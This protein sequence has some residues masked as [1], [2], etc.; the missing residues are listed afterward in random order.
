MFGKKRL[1]K[2]L[3]KPFVSLLLAFAALGLFAFGLSACGPAQPKN[4]F[5]KL[6]PVSSN[7][8]QMEEELAE[9]G[10]KLELTPMQEQ[11]VLEEMWGLE[12]TYSDEELVA[13]IEKERQAEAASDSSVEDSQIE[14]P[15]IDDPVNDPV[16]VKQGE[17]PVT[18]KPVVNKPA[19]PVEAQNQNAPLN[20]T[21]NLNKFLEDRLN[22]NL[23]KKLEQKIAD[24][25]ENYIQGEIKKNGTKGVVTIEPV[26]VKKTEPVTPPA[27]K[28]Q[29]L[30]KGQPLYESDLCRVINLK[31]REVETDLSG[32][33]S[34]DYQLPREL[35]YEHY[36]NISK[37]IKA[38]GLK[39]EATQLK[40]HHFV[41][42]VLPFA[43]RM[44]MLVFAQRLELMR[45]KEK[46][47]TGET[48]SYV[49]A[50]WLKQVRESYRVSESAGI[51]ELLKRVDI[52]PVPLLLAQ[53]I[54][55]SG[56]GTSRFAREGNALF[57]VTA[58][59]NDKNCIKG[60]E[61]RKVCQ[62][63]YSSVSEGVASYIHVLNTVS[64]Y[65]KLR[66]LRAEMRAAGTPLDSMK[67]ASTL[68]RYSANGITYTQ[69][70]RNHMSR[71]NY[72]LKYEFQEVD[73]Q[74]AIESERRQL[75]KN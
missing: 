23:Q 25:N 48:I 37:Y 72:L 14:A 70:I 52:I 56:W 65:E 30:A 22:Q 1:Y 71:N 2:N 16:S 41:C 6:P 28:S 32:L 59:G 15:H 7:P 45:L 24:Q 53:A 38:K 11:S 57:G 8:L 68:T 18:D 61:H 39:V 13:E 21:E 62:R 55:E 27:K 34:S 73:A 10:K 64:S 50:N 47:K 44:N 46:L 17:E 43:I 40:K 33:Y 75:L 35:P 74:A 5:I 20:P 67:L 36:Q 66:T 19:Q 3:G 60:T 26:E 63:K 29:A 4:T 31:S 9:S 58:A 12:R 42:T 54:E 49:D 69:I 51:D